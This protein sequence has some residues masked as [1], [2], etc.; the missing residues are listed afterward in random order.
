MRKFKVGDKV[1][2]K[3]DVGEFGE[4]VGEITKILEGGSYPYYVKLSPTNEVI[5]FREDE[6]EPMCKGKIFIFR[7]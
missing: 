6:L 5:P 2:V 7:K 3:K 4:L 1:R